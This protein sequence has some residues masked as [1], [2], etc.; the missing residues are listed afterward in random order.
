[1]NCDSCINGY[2]YEKN[3]KNCVKENIFKKLWNFVSITISILIVLIILVVVFFFR[4]KNKD[5]DK[6]KRIKINEDMKT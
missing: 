4:T 5:S 3:K 6:K 1:M 2:I